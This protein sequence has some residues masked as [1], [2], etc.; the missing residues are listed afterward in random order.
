MKTLLFNNKTGKIIS[1]IFDEG[2]KVDGKH[3][4]VKPPVYELEYIA[5]IKPSHT[6]KE[7]AFSTWVPDIVLGT[8]T[9]VWEVRAKTESELTAEKEAQA[10]QAEEIINAME[11]KKLLRMTSET[12]P[13]SQQAE[14]PSI[15]PSW[16][17]G[18]EVV[19]GNKYQWSNVLYKCNQTHNTQFD[20]EPQDVPALFTKVPK[21]GDIP[22]WVQPTGAHDCYNNGDKVRFEGSVYESLIDTNVWSPTAYPSGWKKL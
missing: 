12:L 22:D 19:I 11:V 9:Q 5:T 1:R 7:V 17:P 3:Q 21:A 10:Q 14:I 16:K 13:E 15:Y 18:I 20:W 4:I 6:Y 2:Y 8:Y